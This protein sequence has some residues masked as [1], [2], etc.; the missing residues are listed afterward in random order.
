MR[1]YSNATGANCRRVAIY[2]A[3]KGLEIETIDMDLSSGELKTPAFLAKNPAGLVP[4]LELDDGTHIVESTAIIEYLEELHPAPNLIGETPVRR[5]R[6]RAAERV[7]SDLGVVTIAAMQHSHPFFAAR[8]TQVPAVAEALQKS[9][10]QQID[11]LEA[12]IGDSP[13][14]AGDEA[15]IA[16]I[17][18]FP[19]IYTC[20]ERLNVPFAVDRTR[21]SAWYDRFKARRSVE[22]WA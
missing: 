20:R 6:V 7:A 9:V 21:L 22:G 5:A 17:V 14:L 1:L 10:D 11:V 18:L 2:L 3:E 16:D 4:V 12:L 8:V 13:F 19:L 15:T